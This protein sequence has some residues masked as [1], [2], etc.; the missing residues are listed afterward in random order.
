[1]SNN[2]HRSDSLSSLTSLSSKPISGYI[3]LSVE[4]DQAVSEVTV[5]VIQ[6]A[7]VERA[8]GLYVKAYMSVDGKDIK[9]SKQKTKAKAERELH[10]MVTGPGCTVVL[11]PQ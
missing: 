10:S 2:L 4:W 9:S 5:K 8:D 7:G 11:Q 3:L 1:M 6:A